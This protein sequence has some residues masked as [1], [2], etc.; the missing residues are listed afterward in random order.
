MG[1]IIDLERYR[2]QRARRSANSETLGRRRAKERRRMRGERAGSAA[3]A[4]E[5]GGS[6]VDRVAKIDPDGEKAE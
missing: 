6:E 1:E 3:E 4:A 5:D 2:K